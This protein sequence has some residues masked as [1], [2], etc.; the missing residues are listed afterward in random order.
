MYYQNRAQAGKLLAKEL[1]RYAHENAVVVA[2]THGSV[3]VGAQIA[4]QLHTNLLLHLIKSI[5]LP[6][7]NEAIASIGSSGAFSYNNAFSAG[8]LE[9]LRSEFRSTIEQKKFEAFHEFNMLLGEEG[10]IHKELLRHRS[11]ILVA[12][13][14]GTAISLD[15]AAE[16]FKTIA[17]KRLIVAT[18]VA[19]VS[20]VDRMH[21][22]ADEIHCL[23]VTNNFLATDHYYEENTLPGIDDAFKIM[24]NI[25]INWQR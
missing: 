2:L 3:I 18:P 24:R 25:S 14:L 23:S 11:V 16:Y 10:E 6:G 1:E 12:D 20:A 7:E 21:L 15:L 19:S 17:I 4:M 9:E 13:A 8:E 5:Y 22:L